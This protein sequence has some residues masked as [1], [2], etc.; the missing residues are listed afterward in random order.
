VPHHPALRGRSVDV[1]RPF[2]LAPGEILLSFDDGPDPAITPAVQ[3]ALAAHDLKAI[4][5]L[6]GARVEEA[7]ELVIAT[8]MAGHLTGSHT[9]TH[10]H[11]PQLPLADAQQEIRAGH[12]WVGAALGRMPPPL[13]RYPFLERSLEL[14]LFVAAQGLRAIDA[15]IILGD[16]EDVAPDT[17]LARAAERL[18]MSGGG[19]IVLHDI[20]AR[21]AAALPGLLDLLAARGLSVVTPVAS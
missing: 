3:Q 20:H 2:Q 13:F 18:D 10:P 19:T 12:A 8:A 9:L 11:L 14:D 16:W 21:T 6:I 4:F 17:I 7:P 1:T 5:F 15:D